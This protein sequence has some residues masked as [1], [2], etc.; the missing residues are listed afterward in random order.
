MSA[1]NLEYDDEGE[2]EWDGE[3]D[4]EYDDDE[5]D[6][7][8]HAAEIAR[9]IEAQLMADIAANPEGTTSVP[10]S[11][12][13]PPAP[14]APPIATL[15]PLHFS[16]KEE[17][18]TVATVRTILAMLEHD[19]VA[20]GA[21]GAAQVAGYECP[22]T[23]LEVL[24]KIATTA[25]IPKG[26][27]L[28][29]SRAVIEMA[30]SE[31]L[32][33]GLRQSDAPSLILKRKREYSA[34]DEPASKRAHLTPHP[35]H[36]TI[37]TAVRIISYSIPAGRKLEPSIVLSI[38]THLLAV[39]RFASSVAPSQVSQ[40]SRDGLTEVSGFLQVIGVLS[41]I[42]FD[43]PPPENSLDA[44]LFP[45]LVDACKGGRIFVRHNGLRDHERRVHKKG[46]ATTHAVFK[47]EGCEKAF[48]T[49][50]VALQHKEAAEGE[51]KC[52]K[53]QIVETTI[54]LITEPPLPPLTEADREEVDIG[55]LGETIMLVLGL[56]TLLQGQVA[57]AL[58]APMNGT[59]AVNGTG[60]GRLVSG[61]TS[62]SASAAP[63][64]TTLIKN[65]D[66]APSLTSGVQPTPVPTV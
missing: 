44:T 49:R 10:V 23:L 57:R 15:E 37:A 33:G 28:A 30:T 34:D 39:F 18:A 62:A 32:F 42:Q 4:G 56:H 5:D 2:Q 60:A 25:L 65:E 29:I 50:D 13:S 16:T 46:A 11:V 19:T 41:G 43:Q 24:K 66:E 6:I 48:P 52:G 31:T 53:A 8:E 9:R 26:A 21:F 36:A 27:A 7:E 20:K 61:P 35:I 1:E 55:A 12:Q 3:E 14:P 45:C 51:S 63:D 47:C 38:K 64:P 17:A 58:S 40:H 54:T 22:E 59:A